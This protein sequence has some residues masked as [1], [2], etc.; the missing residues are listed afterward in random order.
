MSAAAA[1]RGGLLTGLAPVAR[2]DARV[3]ILGSMPGA[4]SLA[5]RQYYAHPA[6]AFWSL[7]AAVL[8][9]R[10]PETYSARIAM[11]HSHRVALW[12]VVHRC[13]RPGSLDAS[14]DPR[15]VEPN[16]L[17]GFLA[18]QTGIRSV[19]FNG[20]AA[21]TL[22]RR[23]FGSSLDGRLPA[24][25]RR[26]LPSSSPAHASRRFAHKLADWRQIALA[27]GA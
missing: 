14:I 1:E 6:N 23:H 17:A 12:D 20:G 5:A 4:A 13:V 15:S 9:C 10:L 7:M 3:L 22:F 25:C 21:E 16:D 24:A 11:L 18:R 27:L 19:F 26:R 8:D 2:R